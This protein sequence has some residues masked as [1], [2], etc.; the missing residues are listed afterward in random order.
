MRLFA[1]ENLVSPPPNCNWRSIHF[2]FSSRDTRL[3]SYT[4][5]I[6]IVAVNLAGFAAFGATYLDDIR[7][8]SNVLTVWGVVL[9]V[10]VCI[11]AYFAVHE[12]IHTL[13]LPD[14]GMSDRTLVGI[15]PWA[16]FVVYNGEIGRTAMMRCVAAPFFVLLP[17]CV[18]LAVEFPG[19]LC[20]NLIGLHLFACLGDF[21]LWLK[22]AKRVDIESIWSVG[23]EVW[24]KSPQQHPG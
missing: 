1:Q 7:K 17:V 2:G 22:L 5:A 16:V 20:V 11:A 19:V 12:F 21:L 24:I 13:A 15:S 10:A 18:C 4:S 23:S 3:I 14:H 9:F 8:L 6:A